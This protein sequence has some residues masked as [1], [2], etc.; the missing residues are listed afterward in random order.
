MSAV[1]SS[2]STYRKRTA[3]YLV[4][5]FFLLFIDCFL[6]W[7]PLFGSFFES[8]SARSA[9]MRNKKQPYWGW[10]ADA[11]DWVASNIFQQDDHCTYQLQRETQYGG[12]WGAYIASVKANYE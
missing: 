12:A 1:P 5:R 10:T 3:A 4:F 2:E 8:M 7:F 11:I 6:N 9:R